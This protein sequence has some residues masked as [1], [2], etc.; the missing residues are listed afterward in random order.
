MF[1]HLQIYSA[2]SFQ[3]STISIPALVKRAKELHI[4]YLAIT[5][6]HQMYGAM[7]L[8]HACQNA[9]IHPIYGMEMT[10]SYQGNVFPFIL[11]AKDTEGYFALVKLTSR[12]QLSEE[13][14]LD[15]AQLLPYRQHLFFLLSG[16]Q[17]ILYRLLLK[18]MQNEAAAVLKALQE[19][20]KDALT[21][22]LVD[23]GSALQKK[24]NRQLSGMA[25]MFHVRLVCSNEV[26]YLYQQ[27]ALTLKYLD[28]ASKQQVLNVQDQVLSAEAYLKSEEEM[29]ALFPK[30][31]M[32]NTR[33]LFMQCQAQIPT[34][35]LHL[36][37]YPTPKNA[38]SRDYLRALCQVGL[39]KRFQGKEVPGSYWQRLKE[40]LDIIDHM[41]FSDYFLIV[42]DYVRFAKTKGI[43][44]GPGRGSAAGSLVAYVLGITN[45]DPIRYQLIFERFLNPERISMPDIDVDFQDDRREEV[46]DYVIEK[47]GQT[48]V[49]QIV[50]FNTYGP[51]V[52]IKDLGKAAGVSLV[53]L[54]QVAKM[55]PTLPKFKKSA[56]Q[57][58]QESHAFQSAVNK[59]P[60][61][62]RVM[63]SVFVI[64]NL[65]RNISTHAAG[66]VLS[67]DSLENV[68]PLA[69]GPSK[70]IISQYSKD[71]IEEV[72]LLK[73]D[74]L[75]LRNLTILSY[76]LKG[77]EAETGQKLDLNHLPL[78]D[79][80]TFALI[81]AGDTF[82][83]FQ[84]ES[85]GMISLLR[86]IHPEN[87]E[88]VVAAIALFRPG[89]MEN[90]P[91]YLRRRHHQEPIIY[92]HEDLK[93]ILEPTYGI[94][95]YQ[96]QIMQIATTMA[97]F[98]MGKADSLRK[99]ISKK[100]AGLMQEMREAFIQGAMQ[101]GYTKAI[102][103]DVYDN[104]EKFANYGFNR[105][106]SVAYALVACQM[107]YLKVHYPLQ[108][109]AALLSNNQSSDHNKLM[110]M[111]ES[112]KYGVSILRPSINASRDR[113]TV[114]EGNIRYSLLAIKDVGIAS[115]QMINQE[116]EKQGP[117]KDYMDFMRR[118]AAYRLSSKTIEAL[119][120][121]GA[122]DEFQLSRKMMKINLET[123][124]NASLE[125]L[126][127]SLEFDL[128]LKYAEDDRQELLENEKRVLG[129]YLTTHPVVLYRQKVQAKT[130]Q[131]GR[132][133]EA[134]NQNVLTVL[135]IERV[136]IIRDKKGQNMCF[137]TCYDETGSVDCV[138]FSDQY[139]RYQSCLKKGNMILAEGK[140][141]FRNSLSLNI[142]QM[143][144]LS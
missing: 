130:L 79:P 5:D 104:I 28:A 18:E 45:V 37:K 115:Y 31:V 65:P 35:Q 10:V 127:T 78:D 21:I 102:A 43:L 24:I 12:L 119:I 92:I 95:I 56:Y 89:P 40:E 94:L 113:F 59:D 96:E 101:K 83:I 33:R 38:A 17:S 77:I 34:N 141:T 51:R 23:L 72:G 67:D 110:C 124:K 91:A 13:E 25:E 11:L 138:L 144:L 122:L 103:V 54:E 50:T 16:E 121:A 88:D 87:F 46:V 27:E 129:I 80:K 8:T 90:I 86:K 131:V 64:E 61:L 41:Q 136:K 26:R 29:C 118:M 19:Q 133:I 125:T 139:T 81:A 143:R 14:A 57:M 2:Y 123:V 99:A 66:V 42:Y 4:D 48:H 98:T 36:P 55:V 84:L 6:H 32:D 140:I 116:K 93:T 58:Y 76:I 112:R 47:Y 135:C 49:C 107:A 97:G 134:V 100:E 30:A 62:A 82:G 85:E 137:L 108:F 75:G 117:F 53:K 52:A 114:E 1:G 128:V 106:H 7:E 142:R 71:Y 69:L 22:C 3:Q 73:M 9:G 120:D 63:P 109:F 39:R 105:S 132:F 60:A 74:F 20:L 44:V 126:A 68:I 15:F 70:T 111:Q